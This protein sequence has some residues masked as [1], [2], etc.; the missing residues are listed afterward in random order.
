M[1]G[2]IMTKTYDSIQIHMFYSEIKLVDY[3]DKLLSSKSGT[4][5]IETSTAKR[6]VFEHLAKDQGRE[7]AAFL[8]RI[9]AANR[10]ESSSSE[11]VIVLLEKLASLKQKG[12]ISDEEFQQ[13]KARLMR[14]SIK[15]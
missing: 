3:T 2:V 5:T 8:K 14:Q 12:L 4:L 11:D 15:K 9:V 1:P 10:S 6:L 13:E 7:L